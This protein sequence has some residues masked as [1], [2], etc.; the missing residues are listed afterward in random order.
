MTTAPAS[1]S[2]VVMELVGHG[3]GA[4]SIITK[5]PRPFDPAAMMKEV[6]AAMAGAPGPQMAPSPHPGMP[7]VPLGGA[8]APGS[9]AGK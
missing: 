9:P 7:P 3:G 2:P 1:G 4:K 5:P 6:Q 8:A